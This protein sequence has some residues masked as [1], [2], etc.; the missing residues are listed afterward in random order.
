M[1]IVIHDYDSTHKYSDND[2]IK[3]LEFHIDNIFV[4]FGNQI[5]QQ[6]VGIPRGTNCSPLF[7]KLLLYFYEV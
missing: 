4:G 2:I 1:Y 7:A 3:M 6:T 5:F